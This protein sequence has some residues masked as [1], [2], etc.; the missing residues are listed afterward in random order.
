MTEKL[1]Y[2][3]TCPLCTAEMKHLRKQADSNLQLID[4]HASGL[5]DAESEQRLKLLHLETADGNTLT[6]LDAN[7]A[8]WRHTRIGFLWAWLRWPVIR[9]IADAVYNAWATRRFNR[10]Y[11]NG[12]KR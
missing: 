5:S 3:G 11:P 7:V 12:Y 6:G 2:D 1:Y 9:E 8:A 4:V 10:L